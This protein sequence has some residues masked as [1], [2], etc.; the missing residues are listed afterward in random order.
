MSTRRSL[1]LHVV[2]GTALTTIILGS[3]A[4]LLHEPF[5]FPSL[6]PAMFLLFFSPLA[7]MSAPRNVIVGQSIGL[8]SGYLALI[9]FRLQGMPPDIFDLSLLRVAA[10]VFALTLAFGLM[11]GLGFP[12][13]PAGASAM[14][15]ALGIIDTPL[16]LG[17]MM[18]AVLI[19]TLSAFAI[20]RLAGID[21]PVWSPRPQ[22][23]ATEVP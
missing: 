4:Y 16:D 10:V 5:V 23:R 3:F 14:I 21:V 12:H 6:G 11:V 22:P 19:V 20:N 18:L 9:V 13:A 17:I 2:L 7:T 15:V 8:G 1:G